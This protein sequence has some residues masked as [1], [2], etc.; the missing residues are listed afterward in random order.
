[1][2]T[3]LSVLVMCSL[4]STVHAKSFLYVSL[5]RDKQISC[6]ET[7]S[8]TGEL[9]HIENLTTAGAPGAMAVDAT[10]TYLFVALRSTKGVGT[11]KIDAKTGKLTLI[12]TQ[13]VGV[14]P[15]YLS[16][17]KSRSHIFLA[18]Y[19]DGKVA[20]F[21]LSEEGKLNVDQG[22]WFDTEKKA[23]AILFDPSGRFGF[24]PHTGPNAM[25]QFVWNEKQGKLSFN[26]PKKVIAPEGAGPRHLA[27]HPNG[28]YVYTSD[29]LGSSSSVYRLHQQTGQLSHL[30]TLSTLP[31]GFQQ[32]NT[33]A[34]VEISP[35]AKF[36]YVSNRG[37]D[38]I[39]IFAINQT[40]GKL[41]VAGHAPTEKTP[42][43]F[44]LTPDGNFLYAAG[45]A[46]GKLVSY[47]VNQ[48]TGALTPL[49]TRDVGKSP[50]WV[51]AVTMK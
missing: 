18:S 29:E 6:F 31:A 41:S 38:S 32:Q 50:S 4:V 15:V 22:Q 44:N 47:R 2:K 5:G 21:P 11:Y 12:A 40:T 9:T 33:C 7:N 42:R 46:S 48:T 13:T 17:N 20:T 49:N 10:Q 24:V 1:M 27:Y 36:L 43:S 37:H 34:D 51:Q 26:S 35:S 39:A 8:Q 23:H 30:Q 14:N 19:S 16:V 45:Q 28:K 25:Y 3:L